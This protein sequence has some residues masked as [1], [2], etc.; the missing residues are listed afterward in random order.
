MSGFIDLILLVLIVFLL[1]AVGVRAMREVLRGFAARRWPTT[2]GR[3]LSAEVR[4]AAAVMERRRGGVVRQSAAQRYVAQV[5][6]EYGVKG[7]FYRGERV[8]LGQARAFAQPEEAQKVAARYPAGSRVTVAYNPANPADAVLE[9]RM[10]VPTLVWA[11][12]ALLLTLI[13]FVVLAF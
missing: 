8:Q 7:V 6:Y 13:V 11:F 10:G 4:E 9:R 3:V 12:A 1:G 5:S 2:T